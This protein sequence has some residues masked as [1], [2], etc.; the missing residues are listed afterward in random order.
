M[1]CALCVS[2]VSASPHRAELGLVSDLNRI[3]HAPAMVQGVW[4]VEVKAL[5]SG[6]ILY[7][8]NP[9]TLM[10]PASNMKIL[11]LAAAAETLGWDYRFRT[12]L[13]STAPV[14]DG[15]LAGDLVVVGGGDPTINARGNRAAA[16]LDEWASKLKAL[17]V[18]RIDGNIIGDASSFE[19]TELGQ[20]WSWDDLQYGYAAPISA[21]QFNENTATL[22]VAPGAAAGDQARLELAPD[23]G[24]GL[25]HQVVTGEPGSPTAIAV[26][27][28]PNDRWLEVSGSIAADAKPIARDVAVASPA[29]YFARAVLD[30][31]AARGIPVRGLP[32]D[33][34]NQTV[35]ASGPRHVLVESLSPPLRE[36]AATM[37]KVSQ[38]LYAETLLKQTGAV[39]SGAAASADAGRSAA[40]EVLANWNIPDAT[41]VQVDGSGLS[42]YDYV[43]ADLMITILEH[44]FKDPRHREAFMS[45]L[46]IAGRDGTIASRLKNT[47][48]EGNAIA[49][50]GS[51]ANVRA[52]SGYVHTR[53]GETLAFSMLANAF[54]I[55]PATVNWI[56]DVAVETLSN[57]SAR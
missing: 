29:R 21:L 9:R 26:Q 49:K 47:R 7:S 41:Y 57:Y 54:T 20:G 11:T 38:N 45:A 56:A 10:M 40:R 50:T 35:I 17:G 33:R 34:P 8:L 6:R 4:A 5:D 1:L 15:A 43:T 27:R 23:T 22:T 37:M 2:A 28:S 18:T 55:P 46:A 48:A 32:M 31:L 12:T 52:L 19:A 13:E 24:L 42:R 30:G 3:F 39:K 25:V 44:M 53:D 36:I 16:V 51:I 14:Q